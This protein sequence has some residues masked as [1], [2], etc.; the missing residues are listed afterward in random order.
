LA[1]CATKYMEPEKVG[2][3]IV[4]VSKKGGGVG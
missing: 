2:E 3:L 1:S 4:G